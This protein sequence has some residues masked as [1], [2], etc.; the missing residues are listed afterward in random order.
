MGVVAAAVVMQVAILVATQLVNQVALEV[1]QELVD[2]A[3][4]GP[5]VILA[6]HLQLGPHNGG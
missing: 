1:V 6:V 4:Q 5:V 3:A 2:L